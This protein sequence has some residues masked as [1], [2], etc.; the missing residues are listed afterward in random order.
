[1]LYVY[2]IQWCLFSVHE[3]CICPFLPSLAHLENSGV[4]LFEGIPPLQQRHKRWCDQ[5]LKGTLHFSYS[6]LV[7]ILLVRQF[8]S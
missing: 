3:K 4:I 8:V 7:S 1:M 2:L 6:S 5:S